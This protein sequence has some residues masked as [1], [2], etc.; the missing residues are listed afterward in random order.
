MFLHLEE[1]RIVCGDLEAKPFFSTNS[2]K[3]RIIDCGGEYVDY[4]ER[5]TLIEGEINNA[6]YWHF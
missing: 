5:D 1:A 2:R 3:L 4:S 6:L